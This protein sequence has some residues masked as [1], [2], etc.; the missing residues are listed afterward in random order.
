MDLSIHE[1]VVLFMESLSMHTGICQWSWRQ[2]RTMC[3][4]DFAAWVY[5]SC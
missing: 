2:H 1:L 3:S 4:M 5:L